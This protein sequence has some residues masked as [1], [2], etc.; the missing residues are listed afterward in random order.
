MKSGHR[1]VYQRSAKTRLP[2]YELRGPSVMQSFITHRAVAEARAI[3]MLTTNMAS[4]VRY[5]VS[6]AQQ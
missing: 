2:I 3:E 5:L 1:G 6:Q 4:E